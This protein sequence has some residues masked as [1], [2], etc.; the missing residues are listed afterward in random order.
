MHEVLVNHLGGLSLPRNS[1]VRLTDHPNMTLD[2]YRGRK[3]TT[4][5]Q[6][7]KVHYKSQV[8]NINQQF[9]SPNVNYE[10]S[11]PLILSRLDTCFGDIYRQC[12]SMYHLIRVYTVCLR[13]DGPVRWSKRAKFPS[14]SFRLLFVGT[15]VAVISRE[16]CTNTKQQLY[17]AT[18][19]L[20]WL[21][22]GLRR[23]CMELSRFKVT[24]REERP[25]LNSSS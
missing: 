9:I 22:N 12:R 11:Y 8:V 16:D 3:T 1:V 6:L 7:L 17:K 2:V 5:Q 14:F 10:Y 20:T 23:C 25:R 15:L 13:K 18:F 24:L 19:V 21:G 4:Q